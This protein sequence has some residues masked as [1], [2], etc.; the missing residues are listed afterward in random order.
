MSGTSGSG[1]RRLAAACLAV[2]A[3]SMGVSACDSGPG[4]T[5]VADLRVALIVVASPSKSRDALAV[6]AR[7][8]CAERA[9]CQAR[10]WTDR[11]WAPRTTDW[12]PG[13]RENIAL[14]FNKFPN[15]GG[16]YLRWNCRR[17]PQTPPQDCIPF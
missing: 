5:I 10:V 8:A 13:S 15:D 3:L 6:A 9:V 2:A 11:Q 7:S 12:P 14:I 17:Y 16:E 4:Y 1:R